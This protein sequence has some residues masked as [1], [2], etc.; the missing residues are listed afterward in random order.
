MKKLMCLVAV[1][2]LLTTMG[3][4]AE[5]KKHEEGTEESGET[6]ETQKDIETRLP[7]D[8]DVSGTIYGSIYKENSDIDIEVPNTKDP[9]KEKPGGDNSGQGNSNK[10]NHIPNIPNSN[11]DAYGIDVQ[12]LDEDGIAYYKWEEGKEKLTIYTSLFARAKEVKKNVVMRVVS[13]KQ[14][15][16]WYRVRIRYED[17]KDVDVEDIVIT[18]G[19]QCEHKKKIEDILVASEARSLLQCKQEKVQIPVYIGVAVPTDWSHDYGVYQY[20]YKE[21][22]NEL[23]LVRKDLQIDQENVA[24]IKMQEGKDYVFYNE[25]VPVEKRSLMTWVKGL[26]GKSGI[27]DQKNAVIAVV[28]FTA[29]AGALGVGGYLFMEERKRKRNLSDR[30]EDDEAEEQQQ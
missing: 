23:S 2:M 18:F 24:E 21:N 3:I 1:M 17:I 7:F 19:E 28:L 16:L 15:E 6:K 13:K 26:G 14:N 29:G 9:E 10:D 5:D 30:Q 25:V 11:Q 8:R 22:D 20:E 27:V 12:G 4:H